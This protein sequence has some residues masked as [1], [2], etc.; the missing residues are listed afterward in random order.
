[1]FSPFLGT[2]S[3]T[4]RN[5]IAKH[6]RGT[7]QLASFL[8]TFTVSLRIRVPQRFWGSEDRG[9]GRKFG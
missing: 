9:T 6:C 2:Q 7:V 5:T 3:V 8:G 4:H 1:M